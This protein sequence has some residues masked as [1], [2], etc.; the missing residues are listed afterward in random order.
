VLREAGYSG[1][2]IRRLCRE[3]AAVDAGSAADQLSEAEEAKA[4]PL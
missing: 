2:E 4:P 1:A 3:R